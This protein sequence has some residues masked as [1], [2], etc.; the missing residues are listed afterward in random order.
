VQL[1]KKFIIFRGQVIEVYQIAEGKFV[2]TKNVIGSY[3]VIFD[4][5]EDAIYTKLKIRNI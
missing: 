3:S 5:K 2:S 4:N 1:E